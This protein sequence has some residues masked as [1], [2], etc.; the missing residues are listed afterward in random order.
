MLKRGDLLDGHFGTGGTVNS[1]DDHAIC[2]L[3]NDIDHFIR[4]PWV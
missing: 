1:G 3:T 4:G 2:T